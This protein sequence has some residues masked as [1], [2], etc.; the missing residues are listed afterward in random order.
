MGAEAALQQV[1]LRTMEAHIPTLKGQSYLCG[2]S[3]CQG[4]PAA[5][6]PSDSGSLRSHLQH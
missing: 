1:A 4:P 5:G 3:S 6:S 2:S